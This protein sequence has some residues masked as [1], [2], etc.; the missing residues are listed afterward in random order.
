MTAEIDY[1]EAEARWLAAPLRRYEMEIDA[2]GRGMDGDWTAESDPHGD[3]GTLLQVSTVRTGGWC[4]VEEAYTEA[5]AKNVVLILP[6][7]WRPDAPEIMALVAM[8]V[9]HERLVAGLRA[10]VLS[11]GPSS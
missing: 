1:A 3:R 7:D 10:A 9:D 11:G 2:D 8:G 6:K 5:G 4:D